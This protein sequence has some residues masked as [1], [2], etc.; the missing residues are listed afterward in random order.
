MR[1]EISA[2]SVLETT[3]ACGPLHQSQTVGVW[4]YQYC[5]AARM[6]V[7]FHACGSLFDYFV[8]AAFIPC[9]LV[10]TTWYSLF[11]GLWRLH[12]FA[13][14]LDQLPLKTAEE[15]TAYGNQYEAWFEKLY[16][17]AWHQLVHSALDVI[18]V[19]LSVLAF[20]SPLRNSLLRRELTILHKLRIDAIAADPS[21]AANTVGRFEFQY[22]WAMRERVVHHALSSLL[23]YLAVV[24]A[25]L[26]LV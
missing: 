19:P 21:C 5:G 20:I 2:L 8:I 26:A 11:A 6:R 1:R 16:Y 22:S 15:V 13:A 23:D 7:M 12:E 14:A 18:F 10:P 17:H 9:L 25:V 4:N 3:Y 24:P